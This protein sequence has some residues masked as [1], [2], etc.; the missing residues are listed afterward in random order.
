MVTLDIKVVVN[1]L[2]SLRNS[3]KYLGKRKIS[4]TSEVGFT[5]SKMWLHQIGWRHG[6]G[7]KYLLQEEYWEW[8]IPT[9]V[10]KVRVVVK[11]LL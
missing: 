3:V 2:G 7:N 4:L 8:E 1:D 11:I 10:V 6:E 9:L 5:T